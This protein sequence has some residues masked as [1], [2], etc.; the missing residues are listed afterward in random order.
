MTNWTDADFLQVV[1][2]EVR[3]HPL[4]DLIIA[5]CRLVFFEAEARSQTTTSMKAPLLTVVGHHGPVRQGRKWFS[6][7]GIWD[8]RFSLASLDLGV[9]TMGC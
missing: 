8:T 5:E 2:R 9:R 7:H 4:V 1:R 3:E 6:G